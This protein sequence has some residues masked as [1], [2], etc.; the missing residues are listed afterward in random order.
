MPFLP[1]ARPRSRSRWL[2]PL[3]WITGVLSVLLGAAVL[4]AVL[5]LGFPSVLSTPELREIYDMTLIRGLS[6]AGLLAAG[7]CRAA[8]PLLERRNAHGPPR[9]RPSRL[10]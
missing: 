8:S 10:R 2:G 9:I 4:A 7:R 5:C 3:G 6:K 1:S